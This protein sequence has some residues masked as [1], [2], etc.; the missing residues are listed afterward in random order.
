[1][2]DLE[3]T[4]VVEGCLEVGGPLIEMENR[5]KQLLAG[6][7]GIQHVQKPRGRV[8]YGHAQWPLQ[9]QLSWST[10][11]HPSKPYLDFLFPVTVNDPQ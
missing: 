3:K 10:P 11:I 4:G 5:G 6:V 1:M 8:G 9:I 7:Q 2:G